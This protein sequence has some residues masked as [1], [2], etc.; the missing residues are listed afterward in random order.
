VTS[1]DAVATAPT[2]L[3]TIVPQSNVPARPASEVKVLVAN[4]VGVSGAASKVAGS[5]QPIGYELMKP[6]NTV[7]REELS[8][9]Q[10]APGYATEAQA[11]AVT[12]GLP[13]ASV[14]PLPAQAPVTNLQGSNVLVIVGND[15]ANASQALSAAP[16]TANGGTPA[17][18]IPA[19]P[20]AGPLSSAQSVVST[21]VSSLPS[22]G[23]NGTTAPQR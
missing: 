13:P 15:L 4:G 18:T 5:L 19:N 3:S 23:N 16:V 22:V 6:G 7:N 21:V 2:D 12:L 1:D 9:I 8:Q 10:F 17:T 14:Q 11:I 20:L